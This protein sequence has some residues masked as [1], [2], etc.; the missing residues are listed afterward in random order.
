MPLMTC[1]VIVKC[2]ISVMNVK[3]GISEIPIL[4]GKNRASLMNELPPQAVGIRPSTTLVD[5]GLRTL[6]NRSKSQRVVVKEDVAVKS[7]TGRIIASEKI[8]KLIWN[9]L[10]S[11]KGDLALIATHAKL[12]IDIRRV[13]KGLSCPMKGMARRTLNVHLTKIMDLPSRVK[14]KASN[15]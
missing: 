1:H 12:G 9:F 6:A 3:L 15:G 13:R 11:G 8:K 4:K 14:G 2:M 5:I 10:K 7:M